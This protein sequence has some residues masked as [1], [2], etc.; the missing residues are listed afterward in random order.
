[1]EPSLVTYNTVI[2]ACAKA[3]L[4][5]DARRLADEM[6]EAG[7][8]PDVFTLC[9]LVRRPARG[10]RAP[11]A[12]PLPVPCVAGA[13]A[14]AGLS[15]AG[16]RC[17]AG[18]LCPRTWAP[19][20]FWWRLFHGGRTLCAIAPGGRVRCLRGVAASDML[21]GLAALQNPAERASPVVRLMQVAAADGAGVWREAVEEIE[22][23]RAG[24]GVP[25]AAAYNALARAR[26]L[27]QMG[28]SIK[29]MCP[30]PLHTRL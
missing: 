6:A 23:F 25:N 20:S 8:A 1:V 14:V 27:P 11:G 7:I 30:T 10:R 13:V 2:S 16:G 18:A 3:G 24:G 22:R 17:W 12:R 29:H 19:A 9:A 4:W 15:V 5:P 21:T 28:C 26:P